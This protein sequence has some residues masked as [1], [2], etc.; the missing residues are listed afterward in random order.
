MYNPGHTLDKENIF[1]CNPG[2]TLD[3]EKEYL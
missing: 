1:I 3:K 2:Q